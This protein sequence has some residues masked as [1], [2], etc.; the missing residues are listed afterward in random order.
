MQA[1][2]PTVGIYTGLTTNDA[3][4]EDDKTGVFGLPLS[5]LLL[6]GSTETTMEA[7][8]AFGL[9]CNV[10]QTIHFTVETVSAVKNVFKNGSV[11]PSLRTVAARSESVYQS[12][13]SSLL[14]VQPLNGDDHMLVVI[15]GDCLDAAKKLKAEV[16]GLTFP[17]AKGKFAI[18]V[19]RVLQMQLKGSNGR[20]EK[21]N[22]K[23]MAH[24]RVLEAG[25][26]AR[27]W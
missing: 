23:M 26:L 18:A 19:L 4:I 24:Q 15:A 11:D 17:A 25:L 21:L 3:S 14:A 10:M 9:A 20:L 2:A 8:A 27:V 5:I 12:L 6:P 7:L 16:D 22:N 1:P 13:S